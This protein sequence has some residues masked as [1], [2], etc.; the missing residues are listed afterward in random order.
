[1]TIETTGLPEFEARRRSS[2]LEYIYDALKQSFMIGEFVPGQR[3][4]LPVLANAFGT[5]Q[6]PIREATNRLVVARAL[7]ALPRRSLRVPQAT[8]ARLDALLPLRLQLEGEATRLA[9]R[10]GSKSLAAQLKKINDEMYSKPALKD[11]KTFLRLN[12]RFHFTVYEH[13]GNP[14]LVDLIELLWMRY[15]PLMN[16]V[17]NGVL[18]HTGK[19][20]HLELITAIK[21]ED[22]ARASAAIRADIAEAA[23]QIRDVIATHAKHAAESAV[24]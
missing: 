16:V 14:D 10:P 9:T 17:H 11:V 22:P 13:C 24:V 12:Q 7:E 18:S 20:R 19:D 6:M 23:A 5:S 8:T 1:M 4:T 2:D 15:G 21:D 3:V